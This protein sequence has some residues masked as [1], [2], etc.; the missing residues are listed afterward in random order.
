MLFKRLTL[1]VVHPNYQME[2][3]TTKASEILEIFAKAFYVAKSG[4]PGPVLIDITKDAQF[5]SFDFSY[6][7]C[8]GVRSYKPVPS[9]D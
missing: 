6:K 9:I 7:K 8:L 3:S 1:L 5:N 4:R 2:L